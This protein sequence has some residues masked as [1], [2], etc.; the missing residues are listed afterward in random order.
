M[1]NFISEQIFQDSIASK[2]IHLGTPRSVWWVQAVW[3]N[4][5]SDEHTTIGGCPGKYWRKRHLGP[6]SSSFC[7]VGINFTKA[8]KKEESRAD[9]TEPQWLHFPCSMGNEGGSQDSLGLALWCAL[10]VMVWVPLALHN[11]PNAPK[12]GIRIR[13]A[14]EERQHG[15][16]VLKG[17]ALNKH[18]PKN[19]LLRSCWKISVI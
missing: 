16:R 1:F 3:W 18:A 15:L 10:H 13:S 6:L 2:K 5:I 12:Q 11:P 9:C 7:F 14:L 19:Q 17:S 8:L 4:E